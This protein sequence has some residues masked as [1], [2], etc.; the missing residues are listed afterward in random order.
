VTFLHVS[1]RLP[2]LQSKE[3]NLRELSE[4]MGLPHSS[5]IRLIAS[6]SDGDPGL[7]SWNLLERAVDPADRR[8]RTIGRTSDG[9]KLLAKVGRQLADVT[10]R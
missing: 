4:E 9:L 10:S 2:A 3:Q 7:K 6:L 8:E 5:C 1:R